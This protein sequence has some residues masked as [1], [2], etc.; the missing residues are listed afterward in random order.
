MTPM[1]MEPQMSANT[2]ITDVVVWF[3][4]IES[5]D[6]RGIL[7]ALAPEE[8]V[9]LSTENIIGRWQRM[10]TGKDG[11][12]THAIR[13]VGPMKDIWKTLY[14]T[15][16][17]TRVELR[18]VRLADEFL[19]ASTRLFSEWSEEEDEQAFHDL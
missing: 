11:R 18:H 13:P 9:T 3:K 8:Y 15:R 7:A 12:E 2:E 1:M 19:D 14:A 5:N 4:H 16:K 6:L 10:Q 17:N